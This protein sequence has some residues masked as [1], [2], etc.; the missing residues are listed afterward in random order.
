MN[1]M[2]QDIYNS[3]QEIL[4]CDEDIDFC[5]KLLLKITFDCNEWKWIQDVC[6][7]I[8]NSNREKNICGLAYT[9]RFPYGKIA[10]GI[11]VLLQGNFLRSPL[12][13]FGKWG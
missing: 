5:C 4:L 9:L 8:I 3:I 7:D 10:H 6:I 12:E 11:P 1:K 2:T 13:I